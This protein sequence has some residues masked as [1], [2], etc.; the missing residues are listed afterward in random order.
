MRCTV[1]RL[2]EFYARLLHFGLLALREAIALKDLEWAKVETVFLHNIPSLIDEPN[3][4]R[5]RCFWE[6]EREIYIEWVEGCGREH[7]QSR[8]RT[9]YE[10]VWREMEPILREM[11][12]PEAAASQLPAQAGTL[13]KEVQDIINQL[14]ADELPDSDVSAMLDHGSPLVRMNAIACLM[15]RAADDATLLDQVITAIAGPRNHF[16]LMGTVTVAHEAIYLLLKSGITD[17]REMAADLIQGI[18]EPRRADLISYLQSGGVSI[19]PV[20]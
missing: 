3:V 10:P 9:Y 7:I 11:F 5:H 18:P 17:A 4:H 13:I 8:L 19:P 16:R 20:R 2:N 6:T 12:S 14:A 15:R 1:D